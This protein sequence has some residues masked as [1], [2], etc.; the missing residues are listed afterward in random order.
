MGNLSVLCPVIAW[1]QIWCFHQPITLKQVPGDTVPHPRVLEHQGPIFMAV[2]TAFG[3]TA[4]GTRLAR[5]TR[6]GTP[7]AGGH[8]GVSQVEMQELQHLPHGAAPTATPVLTD[9]NLQSHCVPRDRA[10]RGHINTEPGGPWGAQLHPRGAGA[11]SIPGL[12]KQGRW[13]QKSWSQRFWGIC[14]LG[15]ASSGKPSPS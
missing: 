3:T 9:E 13:C 12:L 6:V 5:G 10:Q 7:R 2:G 14:C 15:G 1:H 8:A 4:P 11:C